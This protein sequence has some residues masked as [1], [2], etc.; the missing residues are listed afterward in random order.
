[1]RFRLSQT[2][3]L[4]SFLDTEVPVGG[5]FIAG[6]LDIDTVAVLKGIAP[7]DAVAP[8]VRLVRVDVRRTI[9]CSPV[10]RI[11]L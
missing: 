1:M 10:V 11:V 3:E 5:S 8:V 2:I 7:Q 6:E 4:P 9:S